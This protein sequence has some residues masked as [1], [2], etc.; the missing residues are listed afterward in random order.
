M[1]V[2]GAMVWTVA[3]LLSG[4]ALAPAHAQLGA[5]THSPVPD[6]LKAGAGAPFPRGHYDALDT[7]PDWGGIWFRVF[8]PPKP[9]TPPPAQPKL[10]GQYKAQY[11]AWRAEVAANHGV[12]K[13]TTSHCSPPG[14]PM[15]MQ[16]PQYPYE[17]LFTPGRVTINQE[18]WMQTR[19]IWTDGRTHADDPDPSYFGDSVG[20]WEGGTL[21]VDTIAIKDSLPL[22]MGM[23]HSEK[24]HIVERIH[25]DPAD[26][27][28]LVDE[29]VIDDPDALEEPFAATIHY[30]RDRYGQLLEFECSENDRNPVNADG[31]TLYK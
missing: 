5:P 25:L 1:S 27:D 7:L 14:M 28:L 11:D 15:F 6:G 24:M 20:H 23:T 22:A 26:P 12:V 29:M 8:D 30:R 4:L 9:G 18:A 21:V 2:R 16:I 13:E 17:F 31:Q 3:G 19:H 10:K